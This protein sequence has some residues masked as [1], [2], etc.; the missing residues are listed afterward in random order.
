[1]SNRERIAENFVNRYGSDRLRQVLTAF[2]QGVSGQVIADDLQV[3]RERVRQWKN[4]FG[5]VIMVYQ[6]HPE[7]ERLAASD[8]AVAPKG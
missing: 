3:S 4:A 1:M 8:A 7:V 5:S 2:A 6:I